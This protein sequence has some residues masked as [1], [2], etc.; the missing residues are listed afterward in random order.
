MIKCLGQDIVVLLLLLFVII[1]PEKRFMYYSPD[2]L[3]KLCPKLH[4]LLSITSK[5]QRTKVK[6][7]N[8]SFRNV[9]SN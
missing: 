8:S 6:L 7:E 9:I 3:P 1:F 5:E 2:V 4:K